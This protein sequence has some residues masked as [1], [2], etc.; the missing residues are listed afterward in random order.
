MSSVPLV[1]IL[2]CVRKWLYQ[3]LFQ[4]NGWER[5]R[6]PWHPS[7]ALCGFPVSL[8]LV[9]VPLTF[10]EV[11]YLLLLLLF[12]WLRVLCSFGSSL[13][14]VCCRYLLILVFFLP[15]DIFCKCH[16]FEIVDFKMFLY[17]Q[18]FVHRLAYFLALSSKDLFRLSHW[19]L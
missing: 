8:S 4:H 2:D 7:L 16:T 13:C 11:T 5:L 12:S 6:T 3:F 19:N 1:S 14:R 10:T 9:P 15:R 18:S 17:T